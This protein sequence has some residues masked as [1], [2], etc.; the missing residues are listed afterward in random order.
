[1]L[2]A[3]VLNLCLDTRLVQTQ[4]EQA[5]KLKVLNSGNFGAPA[6]DN[7]YFNAGIRSRSYSPAIGHGS[8]DAAGARDFHKLHHMSV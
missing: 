5:A 7:L 4:S 8:D 2:S 6:I 1:M 3:R